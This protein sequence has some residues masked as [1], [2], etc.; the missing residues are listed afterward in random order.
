[1]VLGGPLAPAA[2]DTATPQTGLWLRTDLLE[3]PQD[4]MDLEDA[5]LPMAVQD[6]IGDAVAYPVNA[7]LEQDDMSLDRVQLVIEDGDEAAEQLANGDLSGAWLEDPYWRQLEGSDLQI[8]LVATMPVAESL[9]GVVFGPRLLDAE[10]DRAV[11]VAF[12]RAVIRTVNTHLGGDYQDDD[13]VV[14]ALAEVTGAEADAIVGTPAWVFDWEI[15]Q[16]TAQRIQHA[17]LDLGGVA[18][19]VPLPE[20]QVVDRSLYG[21]AVRAQ[22]Q[23]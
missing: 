22:D 11:G 10:Q 7:V 16:G 15:R 8:E 6:S 17:L 12:S 2:D 5:G 13:D 23:G 14:T 9:S 4:W 18:Y 3:R 1:V 21:E 20:R 19:E